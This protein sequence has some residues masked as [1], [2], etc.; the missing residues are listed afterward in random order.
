MHKAFTP[1]LLSGLLMSTVA[2]AESDPIEQRQDLME[3][4]GKA[5]K[6]IGSMLKEEEPFDAA[7]AM[8]ALQTWHKT[9]TEVGD[10]F[11]A[12]SET[13]HD[14]EAKSEIWTDRA[15]FEE[16]LSAFGLRV[17][18]AIA[19]NP[20]T[21]AEL[22]AAVSPVFKTCKGCHETYRVEKD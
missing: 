3:N 6:T 9:A 8:A 10:L 2:L 11:P 21:L 12:G 15:G 1:L 16:K 7:Q 14:T 19:A 17:D 18:E 13:G 22:G 4:T 20:A 5:A